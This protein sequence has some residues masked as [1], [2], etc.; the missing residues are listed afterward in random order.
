MNKMFLSTES[1]GASTRTSSTP[2]DKVSHTVESPTAQEFIIF[3]S[4]STGVSNLATRCKV[5][6]I[7]DGVTVASFSPRYK[8]TTENQGIFFFHKVTGKTANFD[9]KI[10]YSST[11]NTNIVTI[12]NARIVV[13]RYD[14]IDN[15]DLQYA[16]ANS[17]AGGL[18]ASMANGASVSF[19]PPTTGDYI[20]LGA[21]GLSPGS[22]SVSVLAQLLADGTAYP[23]V[24]NTTGRWAREA[25]AV[26]A[27]AYHSFFAF[28]RKSLASGSSRTLSVQAQ[29]ES[30]TT[31][32]RQYSRVL[33]FRVDA[34]ASLFFNEA[35]TAT[36]HTTTSTTYV[37]R[38][39]VSA[40]APAS[41]SDYFILAGAI[42]GAVVVTPEAELYQAHVLVDGSEAFMEQ[43]SYQEQSGPA[44]RL[45]MGYAGLVN[46]SAGFTVSI[47][48]RMQNR[49][50]DTAAMKN[51]FVLI[52]KAEDVVTEK[53]VTAK[54]KILAPSEWSE[55]WE[56]TGGNI[57][58]QT[59]TAKARIEKQRLKT[60]TAKARI[61]KAR[62]KTIQA[63]GSIQARITKTVTAKGRISI[64][65]TRFISAKANIRAKQ[66]ETIQAKGRIGQIMVG[67]LFAKGRIEVQKTRQISAKSSILRTFS[68]NL[69][70]KGRIE[71]Q[72]SK[73]ISAKANLRAFR[74][75]NVTAKARIEGLT[76]RRITAKGSIAQ[77][78]TETVTS[79]ARIEISTNRSL[80]AKGNILGQVTRTIS[81]KARMGGGS[82]Q[83]ISAKGR[84][85]IRS[86]EQISAKARIEA[87]KLRS[88]QSRGNIVSQS[89]QS[90][91]AKA[92]I[93]IRGR[94]E[95]T[96]SA[97]ANIFKTQ[98]RTIRA[99]ARIFNPRAKQEINKPTFNNVEMPF[100]SETSIEPVWMSTDTLTI[101]GKTKRDVTARKYRYTLRWTHMSV[102][103]YNAIKDEI[104]ALVPRIFVYEKWPQ[105]FDGI[106][107]WGQLSARRLEYG[108]GND[109]FWSSVT[110]TLTEVN[111]RI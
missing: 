67:S 51:N 94:I 49:T 7:V 28:A 77:K 105:S 33:A 74:I 98:P 97:K 65:K 12:Q 93:T 69:A 13:W 85:E 87:R 54:G 31:G 42:H 106:L 52:I 24:N 109:E 82:Y 107:C 95:V 46:K 23:I 15:L 17:S 84:I 57:V 64:R 2:I 47:E 16:E 76:Y 59:I 43:F 19:T 36:E 108:V 44:D 10:Q 20:V 21:E 79:K 100:P 48:H 14:T 83:A 34:F 1:L 102:A 37:T 88:I 70:S 9:V 96:I 58:P 68:R 73:N 92:K 4:A 91:S 25:P 75:Q 90:I 50:D 89:E 38:S 101:G 6:L 27:N 81:A 35:D 5:D 8:Q 18:T 71:R 26:V 56:Y 22:T 104:N 103:H 11:D 55:V 86:T 41:A 66:T 53:T 80:I 32:Q 111:S 30:G 39:T 72:F 63:R 99:R 60:V 78:F 61:E 40:S 45:S 29:N 110:L 3:F 62:T